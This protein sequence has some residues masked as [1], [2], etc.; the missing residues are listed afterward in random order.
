MPLEYEYI[1]FRVKLGPIMV[2]YEVAFSNYEDCLSGKNDQ[3]KVKNCF[4][5]P[6]V[7]SNRCCID[8]HMS[9]IDN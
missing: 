5:I 4:C 2:S 6:A 3:D 7:Y 1:D 9:I 8:I